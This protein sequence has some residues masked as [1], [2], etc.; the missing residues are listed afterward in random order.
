MSECIV[1]S[2][3]NAKYRRPSQVVVEK[4]IFLAPSFTDL[5]STT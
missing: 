1:E 4:I 5:Y 2:S 3:L